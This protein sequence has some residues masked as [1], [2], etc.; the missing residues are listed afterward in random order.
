MFEKIPSAQ[1]DVVK[2]L[3]GIRDGKWRD[4]IEQYRSTSNSKIKE[5]LPCFTVGGVFNGS[6]DIKNLTSQSG[7]LSLDI[8]EYKE[9]REHLY[10]TLD[11]ELSTSLF[12]LF[13]STGG[14]GYCALVKIKKYDTYEQFQRIYNS[15]YQQLDGKGLGKISKFD[16]LPNLNRL[17]YVSYDPDIY[18]YE[19]AQEWVDELEL[20]YKEVEVVSKGVSKKFSVGSNLS[21]ED[22]FEVVLSKFV[23][24]FGD[25]GANGKPR[26]DFILSLARWCC[27]ADIEERWLTS[28]LQTNYHN[29]ARPEVWSREIAKCVRDSYKSYSA[30]R[31]NFTVTKQ[32]SYDDV[33]KCTN[34]EEVK[35]QIYLLIADKL[36]YT[37]FLK[38]QN[39]SSTFVEKEIK[40]MK[41]ILNYL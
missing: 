7:L 27:R 35:E 2:I 25:Y 4:Q 16:W 12:S 11:L 23:E 41:K 26:H 30:E 5:N 40:F 21:D 28:H 9:D 1:V 14:K 38:N 33:L 20:P 24:H 31:G 13:K 22:K 32:F 15:I 17:R 37:D 8:D 6:K 10:V 29:S 36:N 19:K 39:K 3:E 34:V 18:I